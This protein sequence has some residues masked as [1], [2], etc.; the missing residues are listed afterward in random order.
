MKK[1]I[2]LR[3]VIGM[4]FAVVGCLLLI[5]HL[6]GSA[7]AAAAGSVNTWC[8]IL[9]LVFGMGMIGLSYFQK[10]DEEG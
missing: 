2:D 7:K 10:L 8:G 3:F 5:Y 4:F 9:F 1:L 6:A